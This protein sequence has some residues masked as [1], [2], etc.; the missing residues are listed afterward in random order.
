MYLRTIGCRFTQMNVYFLVMN[1]KRCNCQIFQS[2]DGKKG[3]NTSFKSL[4]SKVDFPGKSFFKK[5]EMKRTSDKLAKP[6]RKQ[7]RH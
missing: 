3:K 6:G 5:A 1:S 4:C 2:P 7:T